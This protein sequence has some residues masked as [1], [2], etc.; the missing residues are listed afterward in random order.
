MDTVN[1]LMS[2]GAG[3]FWK[4][5]DTVCVIPSVLIVMVYTIVMQAA[6]ALYLGTAVT[7]TLSMLAC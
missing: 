7:A 1:D 3:Y 2:C 5:K 6:L 4:W